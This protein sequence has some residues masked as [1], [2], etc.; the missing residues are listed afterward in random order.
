MKN[1]VILTPI[2]SKAKIKE[3]VEE[4][5]YSYFSVFVKNGYS[6]LVFGIDKNAIVD[7]NQAE[8]R[9]RQRCKELKIPYPAYDKT[10]LKIRSSGMVSLF[11][12]FLE[13]FEYPKIK[14][15]VDRGYYSLLAN[16]EPHTLK[17]I[18]EKLKRES[19]ERMEKLEEERLVAE[20][21]RLEKNNSRHLIMSEDEE[22]EDDTPEEDRVLNLR[23]IRSKQ[24]VGRDEA[25]N[26]MDSL[27]WDNII[28]KVQNNLAS[29]SD[30]ATECN[31][32]YAGI[33]YRLKKMGV[34]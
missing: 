16:R 18:L 34:L 6:F 15:E 31:V 7:I 29:L 25:R 1:K 17:E 14:V 28:Y 2:K 3:F 32:S 22:D 26:R 24:R 4:S 27:D 23:K 21:E 19:D 8:E 20:E 11:Y 10:E 5:S 13:T 12:E 33:R 30:I 9:E